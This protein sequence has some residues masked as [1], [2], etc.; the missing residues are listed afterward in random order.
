MCFCAIAYMVDT[1]KG[2][3]TFQL[4]VIYVQLEQSEMHSF[5]IAVA[6]LESGLA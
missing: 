6:E 2:K 1:P 3:L 5:A 4:I